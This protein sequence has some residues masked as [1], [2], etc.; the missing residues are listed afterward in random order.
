MN[1]FLMNCPFQKGFHIIHWFEVPCKWNLEGV[2]G[3]HCL[4]MCR[5]Y[6]GNV[7]LSTFFQLKEYA[8]QKQRQGSNKCTCCLHCKK[9]YSCLRVVVTNSGH[10]MHI[11]VEFTT[12]KTLSLDFSLRVGIPSFMP[13][14]IYLIL[15]CTIT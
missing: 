13:F 8:H 14:I 4:C 10:K 12:I 5:G 9:I 1:I 7:Y 3:I 6:L 2:F 11:S 15:L